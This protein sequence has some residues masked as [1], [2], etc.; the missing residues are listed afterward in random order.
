MGHSGVLVAI[1][2]AVKQFN[3]QR[4]TYQCSFVDSDRETLKQEKTT[5]SEEMFGD[6]QWVVGYVVTR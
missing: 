5:A 6:I 4:H 1:N 2:E 3:D